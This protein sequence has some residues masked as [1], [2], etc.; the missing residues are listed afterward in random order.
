MKPYKYLIISIT[1]IALFV[2]IGMVVLQ[3]KMHQYQ[4]MT[5]CAR[6]CAIYARIMPVLKSADNLE[7]VLFY[8]QR[9]AETHEYMASMVPT[10]RWSPMWLVAYNDS[11]KEMQKVSEI[12]D[13]AL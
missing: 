4:L 3:E 7:I 9:I 5:F 13:G 6:E 11:K 1:I 12:E 10:N 2:L 8:T